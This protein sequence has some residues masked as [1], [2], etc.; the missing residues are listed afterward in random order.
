MTD[1]FG[2]TPTPTPP[3]PTLTCGRSSLGRPIRR[4]WTSG[5]VWT[6]WR[7]E[8]SLVTVKNRKGCPCLPSLRI[9]TVATEQSQPLQFAWRIYWRK[10]RG[11]SVRI[12]F[13]Q[14]ELRTQWIWSKK[15][16]GCERGCGVVCRSVSSLHIA[17]ECVL[18]LGI[19][20]V[21]I[22]VNSVR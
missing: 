8:G 15:Q 16:Y 18:E 2:P 1:L 22:Y 17:E 11:N 3:H 5:S 14:E 12:D 20:L 4:S 7:R 6:I 19:W 10:S 9:V 13:V 21:V